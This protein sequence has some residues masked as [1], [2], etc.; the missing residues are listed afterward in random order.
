M[1]GSDDYVIVPR[2][3]VKAGEIK[4][5]TSFS[6]SSVTP[7]IGGSVSS[8]VI[9]SAA[10][11]VDKKASQSSENDSKMPSPNFALK[12]S[13]KYGDITTSKFETT[14]SYEGLITI[15]PSTRVS[16][17]VSLSPWSCNEFTEFTKLYQNY[18][19]VKI[20]I[21][22]DFGQLLKGSY[23][24]ASGA[25]TTTM[26]DYGTSWGSVVTHPDTVTLADNWGEFIDCSQFKQYPC[27]AARPLHKRVFK[28]TNVLVYNGTSGY[29]TLS[30]GWQ[31]TSDAANHT[32]ARSFLCSK[33]ATTG[34]TGITIDWM[35]KYYVRF[36]DRKYS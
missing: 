23:S 9:A 29:N 36:K 22:W 8:V 30:R 24:N 4:G 15:T 3:S 27:C 25:S 13:K 2:S 17:S 11:S 20:E 6:S 35:V 18:E 34:V 16:S 12:F 31:N 5:V 33:A 10:T 7:M 28:P 1:S 32:W 19:C 14:M 26:W 21:T